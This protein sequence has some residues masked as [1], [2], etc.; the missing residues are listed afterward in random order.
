VLPASSVST[1]AGD[2]RRLISIKSF[3]CYCPT[4]YR[5]LSFGTSMRAHQIMTS[6]VV[7][8]GSDASI[9]SA[10]EIM[11]RYH[12]SGLPVLDAAGRL[13]GIVSEGDFVRRAEIGTQHR[14]GRWLQ[15]LAGARRTAAEFVHE[16]G[17]TVGDIMT[18]N[19]F[20]ITEDASLDEI[21]QI[22]Q[23]HNIKRLP[24][25]RGDHVIGIVTRSD[26][27]PAVAGIARDIPSAVVEDDRLRQ[28]IITEI[29]QAAWR[30]CKLKVAVS[31]GVV[32][33]S[34]IVT[35]DNARRAAIVAAENV[36]GAREVIDNF[37]DGSDNPP[38]EEDLGGGDFVSLQAQPSTTDDEPL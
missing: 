24:V 36:P 31:D 23:S 13:I 9:A 33:L 35:D 21:A 8:V 7:T 26:F 5:I 28:K 3:A 32:T 12:I 10:V 1:L 25:M 29:G 18:P 17:R 2:H 38:P 4:L 16:H 20:T 19:P 27:L 15:Y 34:G 30:P 6:H 14:R 22:M 37:C 11:L